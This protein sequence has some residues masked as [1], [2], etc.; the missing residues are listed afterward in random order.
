MTRITTDDIIRATCDHYQLRRANV[1]KSWPTRDYLWPRWIAMYLCREITG[2]SLP[3]IARFFD[4][5]DHTTVLYSH[6]AVRK[7]LPDNDCLQSEIAAVASFARAYAERRTRWFHAR[8]SE[9]MSQIIP[10]PPQIAEMMRVIPRLPK[11][12]VR[13]Q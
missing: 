8:A 4:E 7:A 13:L 11:A 1:V 2:R 12:T 6:N 10:P 9:P 3:D 5:C